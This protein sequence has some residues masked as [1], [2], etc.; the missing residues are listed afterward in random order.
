R[1][2]FFECGQC[3]GGVLIR[4]QPA[5]KPCL[6]TGAKT[7]SD[8]GAESPSPRPSPIGWERENRPPSVGVSSRFGSCERPVWL[9]PLPSDGRGSG[10]GPFCLKYASC[11]ALVFAKTLSVTS[12]LS[13]SSRIVA[14]PVAAEVTRRK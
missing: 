8:F 9:F 13:V 6:R 12:E 3:R 10:C 4:S 2:G 14:R 5:A 1:R 11:S 7:T